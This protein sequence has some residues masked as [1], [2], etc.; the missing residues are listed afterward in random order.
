MGEFGELYLTD[1]L[2]KYLDRDERVEEGENIME[3]E[4]FENV[5]DEEDRKRV[6]EEKK[7]NRKARKTKEAFREELLEYVRKTRRESRE[8][9]KG[10]QF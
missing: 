2:L 3:W 9:G 6:V 10:P 4:E 1:L 5:F 7:K 8:Q